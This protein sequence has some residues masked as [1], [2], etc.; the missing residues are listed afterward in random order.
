PNLTAEFA[1]KKR[2][3]VF[4]A[5]RK[6]LEQ[7]RRLKEEAPVKK[8]KGKLTREVKKIQVK[9]QSTATKRAASKQKKV[10]Q[11][12][13]P[14]KGGSTT[15]TST[16]SLQ[17]VES[18]VPVPVVRVW[19]LLQ[20][21]AIKHCEEMSRIEEEKMEQDR[22][23]QYKKT[24]VMN[25][26]DEEADPES[27]LEEDIARLFPS[28]EDEIRRIAEEEERKELQDGFFDA[29]VAK[30]LEQ[31]AADQQ[32]GAVVQQSGHQQQQREKNLVDQKQ[33]DLLCKYA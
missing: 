16:S 9:K 31:T 26:V 25:G 15:S 30:G 6:V 23:F 18:I 14:R 19:T 27:D 8:V 20:Q 10:H 7:K 33:L 22:Q 3:A 5:K 2:E 28:N 24:G 32:M 1:R 4:L 21:V 12:G 17:P 29:D 11:S 13:G